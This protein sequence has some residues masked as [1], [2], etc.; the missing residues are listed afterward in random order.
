MLRALDSEGRFVSYGTYVRWETGDTFGVFPDDV[1]SVRDDV[2]NELVVAKRSA[3]YGFKLCRLG[4][5]D[6][7]PLAIQC[8]RPVIEICCTPAADR[9]FGFACWYAYT[10]GP[11]VVRFAQAGDPRLN[12]LPIMH[13]D[14]GGEVG[15]LVGMYMV[16]SWAEDA[17]AECVPSDLFSDAPLDGWDTR[18]G[19]VT[20]EV[21]SGWGNAS[22][23]PSST[24]LM[25][26]PR[27][28]EINEDMVFVESYDKQAKWVAHIAP[29]RDFVREDECR[30]LKDAFAEV[31]RRLEVGE[32][33]LKWSN[34]TCI[35]VIKDP[36]AWGFAFRDVASSCAASSS[37]E[38]GK[39]KEEGVIWTGY[40]CVDWY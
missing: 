14:P 23:S 28:I 20:T 33:Q 34:G 37:S 24:L 31:V 16:R 26:P 39:T 8:A 15:A 30:F 3:R 7:E 4:R 5:D 40:A 29:D 2:G 12:G 11:C 32:R 36:V 35:D 38:A 6:V 17:H 22:D 25:P 1:R 18:R 27:A 13:Y 9:L 10:S 19:D 21:L